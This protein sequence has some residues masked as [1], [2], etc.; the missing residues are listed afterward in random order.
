MEQVFEAFQ[1]DYAWRA[2]AASVMV[3]LMCGVLGCFL[4]LRGMSMFGDALSH[5]VL[6]GI[7]VAFLLAGGYSALGFFLGSVGAGLLTAVLITWIQQRVATKNDA[8]IG[9]VFTTMFALGVIGISWLSRNHHAHIDLKDFLF[10]N[11]LGVSDTDLVL[12]GMVCLYVLGSIGLFYRP[13]FATTF[14]PVIAHTMGIRTKVVH[15]FLMMLLSFAVVAALQTVGVILVVSML[16]TP[17]ATA[18]LLSQ[19]LPV[20]LGLAGGVGV[21][22]AVSGLLGAFAFNTTPG[23]AMAVAASVCYAG[24]VAFAPKRGLVSKQLQV[25][26]RR[27]R[28]LLEDVLKEGLRLQSRDELTREALAAR[29][30]TPAGKV[31][32]ALSQ[33]QR[34]GMVQQRPLRLTSKGELAALKL[35]RAHRLYETYLVDRLGLDQEHIHDEAERLEHDLTD[36]LLADIDHDLGY[37]DTD[38]HGSPIPRR[39]QD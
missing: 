35:V 27:R 14:Q 5:A 13:L 2:L 19:R 4:V 26:R 33:L 11:A 32:S 28:I 24:A 25:R 16:I 1:Y 3:G 37:P 30:Q 21:L 15:Y 8:A 39:S 31:K 22:A 17:A 36:E 29:V 34:R 23:P 38:P 9:I 18:L 7:V 20:V 12:T 10:G 6:P